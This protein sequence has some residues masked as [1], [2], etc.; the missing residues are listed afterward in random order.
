MLFICF[1]YFL[2]EVPCIPSPQGGHLQSTMGAVPSGPSN[3]GADTTYP[4]D[5]YP[6][7]IEGKLIPSG[8][9]VACL[10][11]VWPSPNWRVAPHRSFLPCHLCHSSNCMSLPWAENGACA[12]GLHPIYVYSTAYRS[13]RPLD[14]TNAL[15]RFQ[16]VCYSILWTLCS[17]ADRKQG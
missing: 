15:H 13:S 12:C 3:R 6:T 16:C 17:Q 4:T 1:W 2:E 9:W 5:V 7:T 11:Q 8:G 14:K 10:F